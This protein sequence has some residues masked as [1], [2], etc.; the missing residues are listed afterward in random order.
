MLRPLLWLVG[1]GF[2][3]ASL[4][5]DAPFGELRDLYFGEALYYAQQGD[6][7]DAIAR[8]DAELGQ[9]YGVDEPELDSFHAHVGHAEFSVG[10]FELSYRM[11]HRAGRAIEAVLEANVP[12]E[13]RNEAA[14]RLA[15]I[16]FQKAQPV[17]ALHALSRI[18]GQVPERIRD[19]LAFLRAQVHMATGRF[20]AA[21]G[22]LE[23][24]QESPGYT[25]FAGYNHGVALL[26]DGKESAGF[27]A[28]DRAGQVRG[29]RA[30]TLAI[31]DKA[32]LVLGSR[33]LDADQPEEAKQYFDRVRMSGPFSNKALLGSGWADAAGERFERALVPWTILAQRNVTDE[34]V[35]EALL[36]V[37][38]AYGRLGV[39]GNAALGY[40]RALDAFGTEL[41]KLERSITSIREGKFLEAMVR[42][43][44]KQDS[45][46]MLKL[47]SLPET[48]ETYYLMELMASHDFQSSLKN[49]LDLDALAKRIAVWA[50]SLDAYEDLIDARRRYYE[51]VLPAID[52]DFRRLDSRMRLRM[53]Q[54]D[55]L[56]SRLQAMLIAPRPEL[57]ATAAERVIGEELHALEQRAL[58]A[59]GDPATLHR[60]RRLK[61][62][63]HWRIHTEYDQR[64]T[65]AHTNLRAL[66]GVVA[67]LKRQYT[68]FVRTRQAA[69]QSYQGYEGTISQLRMRVREADARVQVLI[70]RQGHMLEAM[71]IHELE[72]R[73]AR[74][75]EFQ[76]NARFAMADSYDRAIRVEA[77]RAVEAH[78]VSAQPAEPADESAPTPAE[79]AH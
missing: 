73:R 54:R 79:A 47:R 9:H 26:R 36:A 4:A 35:Q 14:Y 15:R 75:E 7:F 30:E 61:G 16:H 31:R 78:G 51:P 53:E 34:H 24:L 76:V 1:A 57:L 41:D 66:D 39:Y 27:R 29:A 52:Y 45:N 5:A 62:V 11:H 60:I 22:I 13:V 67:D 40:G 71:A 68:S 2:A 18:Q 56:E 44:I 72:R 38:Y 17:N 69:T 74:L 58:R 19:D 46:W 49:Y 42:E 63:M 25:G 65:E 3:S 20:G 33:L 10:D 55:R 8:L 23:S 50:Q 32:N 21:A 37:P 6:Y 28:L 43:E 77:E 12:D 48:P 59:G 64:L 70:A